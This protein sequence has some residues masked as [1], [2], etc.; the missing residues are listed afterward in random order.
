MIHP[1]RLDRIIHASPLSLKYISKVTLRFSNEN[2]LAKSF[3]RDYFP[4][5]AHENPHIQFHNKCVENKPE[6]CVIHL[7]DGSS[8]VFN[9]RFY[10]Y[11]QQLMQRILDLN[12]D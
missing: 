5:M 12:D 8:R 1:R 11:P 2:K 10:L 4:L 6:H 7:E 3:V 9:L